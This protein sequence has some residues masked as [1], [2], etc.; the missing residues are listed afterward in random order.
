MQKKFKLGAALLAVAVA[1]TMFSGFAPA[2]VSKIGVPDTASKATKTPKATK[3]PKAT[4]KPTPAVGL[5]VFGKINIPNTRINYNVMGAVDNDYYMTRDEEGKKD[6]NGSIFLDFRNRDTARR[7]NLIIYGHNMKSGK[8]FADLHKFEDESFFNT[9]GTFEVELFGKK[10]EYKL[11]CVGQYNVSKFKFDRTQFENDA[12]YT[13]FIAEVLSY[14]TFKD[15][16]Y[17][18]AAADE[19][20]TLATCVQSVKTDRWVGFARRIKELPMPSPTIPVTATPKS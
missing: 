8:M 15:A 18:P 19:I 17:T 12:D 10:W 16:S 7:K 5:G 20:M 4:A 14:A 3:K 9:N 6:V 1:A 2:P 13:G 11:F